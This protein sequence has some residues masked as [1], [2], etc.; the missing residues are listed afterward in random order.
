MLGECSPGGLPFCLP[1]QRWD[2]AFHG[3][4]D[5][6]AAETFR[7]SGGVL[8]G[9]MEPLL[10]LVGDVHS[11]PGLSAWRGKHCPQGGLVPAPG[12]PQEARGSLRRRGSADSFPS[13]SQLLGLWPPLFLLFALQGSFLPKG[14][15]LFLLELYPINCLF[16]LGG[17]SAW[18]TALLGSSLFLQTQ[19]LPAFVNGGW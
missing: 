1:G 15:Y 10:L 14:L 13:S 18:V 4:H 17:C 2:P 6:A 12:P 16:L 19:C 8:E 9:K 11:L 3:T 5:Q 7:I